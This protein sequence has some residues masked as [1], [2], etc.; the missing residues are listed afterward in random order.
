MKKDTKTNVSV[1]APDATRKWG[2]VMKFDNDLDREPGIHQKGNKR[3][4]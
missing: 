4:K 3:D 2:Y 1:E